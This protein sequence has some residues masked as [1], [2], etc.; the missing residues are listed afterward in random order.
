MIK[1]IRTRMIGRRMIRIRRIRTK[2]ITINMK[3]TKIMIKI[4]TRI[5]N[6]Q[7]YNKE[8]VTRKGG[9]GCCV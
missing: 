7:T 6:D 8:A 3:T 9:S 5:R 1:M 2:M 4:R